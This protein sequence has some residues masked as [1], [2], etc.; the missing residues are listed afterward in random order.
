MILKSKRLHQQLGTGLGRQ[1]D[2]I[3]RNE[4]PV[5]K[6]TLIEVREGHW[7]EGELKKCSRVIDVFCVFYLAVIHSVC[8][9]QFHQSE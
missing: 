8:N 3:G 6:S 7:V 1:H 5:N 2:F 9:Y 4:V